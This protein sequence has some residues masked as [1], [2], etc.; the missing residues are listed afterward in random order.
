[1]QEARVVVALVQVL[2]DGAEDLRLIVWEADT[3]LAWGGEELI[4]A[5]GGE[6]RRARQHI[7]MGGEQTLV[8]ADDYRDDSAVQLGGGASN[9]RRRLWRCRLIQDLAHPLL[10][11]VAE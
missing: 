2:E 8:L 6:P 7:L 4:T 11:I 5:G 3:A 10:G 1:M 9:G